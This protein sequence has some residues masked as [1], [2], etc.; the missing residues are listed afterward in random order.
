[1]E[2]IDGESQIYPLLMQYLTHTKQVESAYLQLM[3]E[4]KSIHGKIENEGYKMS[5]E[6]KKM[7]ELRE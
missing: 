3:E 4:Y 6:S 5:Q 1:M 2:G 7:N